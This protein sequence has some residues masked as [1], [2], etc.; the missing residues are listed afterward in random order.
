MS[1]SED[2]VIALYCHCER[3]MRLVAIQLEERSDGAGHVDVFRWIATSSRGAGR[4]AMT[5]GEA[6]TGF[7]WIAAPSAEPDGSQ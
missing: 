4:L 7:S 5:S 2:R 6:A 3:R 1:S